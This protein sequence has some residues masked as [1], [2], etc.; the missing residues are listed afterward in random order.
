MMVATEAITPASLRAPSRALPPRCSPTGH[1]ID[2]DVLAVAIWVG[3][4]ELPR[5]EAPTRIPTRPTN[6]ARQNKKEKPEDSNENG[7]LGLSRERGACEKSMWMEDFSSH[8][9]HIPVPR[10]STSRWFGNCRYVLLILFWKMID[11][12][13]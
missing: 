9:A 6:A 2:E 3:F 7:L 11:G 10:I 12:W 8:L 13:Y 1:Q 5:P 4:W